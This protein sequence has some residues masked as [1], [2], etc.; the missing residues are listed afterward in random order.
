MGGW[1]YKRNWMGFR[2]RG[3][4]LRLNASIVLQKQAAVTVYLE[5]EQLLLFVCVRHSCRAGAFSSENLAAGWVLLHTVHVS[6]PRIWKGV[7]A[8][9]Q[10]GRYT[11]SY[12]RGLQ[13]W[14]PFLGSLILFS[15][16]PLDS[17][18]TRLKKLPCISTFS[19][20]STSSYLWLIR[21]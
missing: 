5:S 1:T 15:L 8:T 16:V 12:T 19:T 11:L 18:T 7:S 2:S 3:L 4:S 14:P 20:Y 13:C 6:S 9:L 10:S 17:C 21:I